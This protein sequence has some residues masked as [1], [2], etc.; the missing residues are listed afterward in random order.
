MDRIEA[1]L[2]SFLPEEE[3]DTTIRL[4]SPTELEIVALAP[5]LRPS[6]ADSRLKKHIEILR[7]LTSK[8]KESMLTLAIFDRIWVLLVQF[9]VEMIKLSENPKLDWGCTQQ[10]Y[11]KKEFEKQCGESSQWVTKILIKARRFMILFNAQPTYLAELKY[12]QASK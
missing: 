2:E 6:E 8:T 3:C 11:A 1:A 9:E 4:P 5:N 10:S 12:N 7:C